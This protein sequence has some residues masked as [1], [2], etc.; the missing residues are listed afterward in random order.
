MCIVA[1]LP[2]PTMKDLAN[3]IITNQPYEL[4]LELN[5]D[6]RQLDILVANYP[7]DHARQLREILLLY[8]RQCEQLSWIQVATAL[9]T[10]GERRTAKTIMDKFGVEHGVEHHNALLYNIQFIGVMLT[11]SI[12]DSHYLSK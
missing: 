9:R 8:L 10:I 1:S 6:V 12:Q 5:I 4:G 2:E 3:I 7:T 11:V